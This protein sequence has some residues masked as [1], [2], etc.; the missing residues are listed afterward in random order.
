MPINFPLFVRTKD[1]GEVALFNSV[2]ELQ[3]QIEKIDVENGE[4]EGWDKDGLPV[5][6]KLQEPALW[7]RLEPSAEDRK[8]D[9]LRAALFEFAKSVGVRLP[10]QIPTSAFVTALEQIRAE[11]EKKILAKSPVRRFFARFK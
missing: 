9:Q 3:F 2:E 11:Q 4:Y 1:S 7:I 5:Q 10:D 8:P 6:I